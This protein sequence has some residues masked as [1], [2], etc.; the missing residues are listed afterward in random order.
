VSHGEFEITVVVGEGFG[1]GEERDEVFGCALVSDG[2]KT[3]AEQ[4]GNG[5]RFIDIN[6]AIGRWEV[7]A[8]DCLLGL[9]GQ[10][11]PAR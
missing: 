9:C 4:P 7:A 2:Q 10:S 11:G 8:C 1:E 3:A 6:R 5:V